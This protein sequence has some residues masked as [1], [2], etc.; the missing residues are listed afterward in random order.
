MLVQYSVPNAQSAWLVRSKPYSASFSKYSECRVPMV[1]KSVQY[2]VYTIQCAYY[3]GCELAICIPFLQA[4]VCFQIWHRARSMTT[5]SMSALNRFSTSNL[6]SPCIPIAQI[7]M[8]TAMSL[9]KGV[10][11]FNVYK[12]KKKILIQSWAISVVSISCKVT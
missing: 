11:M 4:I 12:K 2:I 3:T 6:T 5:Q 9:L 1:V 8:H 7:I 10:L